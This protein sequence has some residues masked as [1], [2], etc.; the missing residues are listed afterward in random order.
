[1]VNT[2]GSQIATDTHVRFIVRDA[3]K[4]FCEGCSAV[5]GVVSGVVVVGGIN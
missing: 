2:Q 4:L 5:A 1:M 3:D